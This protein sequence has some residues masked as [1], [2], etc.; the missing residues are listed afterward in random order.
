LRLDCQAEFVSLLNAIV[1]QLEAGTPGHRVLELLFEALRT[2]AD[3]HGLDRKKLE[4][5]ER[6][7]R[8]LRRIASHRSRKAH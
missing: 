8:I 1:A 4:L 5:D 6:C 7:D 2:L 3:L